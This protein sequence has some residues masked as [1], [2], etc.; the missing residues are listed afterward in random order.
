MLGECFID[1]DLAAAAAKKTRVT[2]ALIIFRRYYPIRIS[3]IHLIE[4]EMLE[5]WGSVTTGSAKEDVAIASGMRTA[6]FTIAGMAVVLAEGATF[7]VASPE[8]ASEIFDIIQKHLQG[9]MM[10]INNSFNKRTAPMQGLRELEALAE[11]LYP[12]AMRHRNAIEVESHLFRALRDRIGTRSSI[13]RN[14]LPLKVKGEEPQLKPYQP[15]TED[16]SNELKKRG[17]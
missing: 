15:Y 10:S 17:G 2:P 8:V 9:W 13:R 5:K 14:P 1:P 7:T 6:N 3:G 4:E 11:Y 16:M 12:F